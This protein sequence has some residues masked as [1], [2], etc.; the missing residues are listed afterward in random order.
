[1]AERPSE[2]IHGLWLTLGVYLL[3]LA[4]KLVAYFL[5]GVMALFAEAL[6]TLSDIF[7]SGFRS[8]KLCFL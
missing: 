8:Q 5:T 4:L 2:D 3:I 7:I 1:M 6:H